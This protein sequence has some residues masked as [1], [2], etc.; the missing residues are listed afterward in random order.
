MFDATKV[1]IFLH[2]RPEF[3]TFALFFNKNEEIC[4]E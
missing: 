2:I 4:Y 1:Q 3:C